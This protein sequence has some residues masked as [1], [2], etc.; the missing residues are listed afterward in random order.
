MKKI[1]FGILIVGLAAQSCTKVN[2]TV[3]D[4][5]AAN[6]FY[7]TPAGQ[8]DALASIYGQITGTWSSN[9]AGRDN[10][11]YDINEFSSDEQVIPHRADNNWALDYAQLYTRTEQPSLGEI[12]NT[13][14]W[15]YTTLHAANLA[16]STLQ[17]AKASP[18]SIAEATVARDWVYYL[19][20]DDFGDVPFYTDVNTNLSTIKQTPRATIYNFL[21]ND[22][23]ANVDLLPT[24]R[25]GTF[26]NRF[27]KYAGYMVLAKLYLNAGVYT[28]TPQWQACLDACAQIAAGGYTLHPATAN[29]ASPLGNTY[30]DLFADVCPNDETIFALYLTENIES[31]NIYSIRSLGTATGN[32]FFGYAGWNG[33]FIPE[34]FYNKFDPNDVRIKQFLIGSQPGGSVF[35][36]TV[37]SLTNAEVDG[38]IRDVKFYVES[39]TSGTFGGIHDASGAS[40]DFPVYRFADVL[41]MEAECNVRLGNVPAAA[42]FL[43]QVRER[44]GLADIAA[45]TL[46]NI[47]DERG[48]ELNMEGHRRQDMIRFGTYLDAHGFVPASAAFNELFP[49]PTAQLSIDP[50]L[51]QNPGYTN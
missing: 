31:G 20:I 8:Q 10:C 7:A 3:Y 16:I 2:E 41:L 13:W 29:T 22:L 14:L 50:S 26:Y 18:A 12:N 21:I 39:N 35:T 30:Y 46:T 42:P 38:G 36:P 19:L 4:K 25:G 37:S 43:N 33:T 17:A 5:Y 27:N 11:W 23:K 49:I 51:K 28:G 48:F 15:A 34:E 32:A 45:P 40:N 47:Y 6:A 24:T 44:A 9:Y 1:L